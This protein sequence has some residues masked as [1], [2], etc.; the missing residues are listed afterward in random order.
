MLPPITVAFVSHH[1]HLRMG[2]QRSMVLLIEHL[3]RTRV[4]P[5]AICPGP[6]ELTERLRVLD[7]PVTHIPLYRIKPRTLRRVWESS[8]R[9]RALLRQRAVDIVAPDAAR[10]AFTCGLAKLGTPT[11]MVWFVRLTGP[12]NLDFINQHLAD[13][14]IGDSD[15][16]RKRFS[17]S[18]RVSLKYR[19]IVGGVD[20][21]LF[22]PVEDRGP[23]RRQLSLPLDRFILLFVGQIKRAKGV[24]DIVDAMALL[25]RERP[26]DR[27]PLLLLV[28][29][30]DPRE[31]LEEIARRAAAGGV[32]EHVRV[33]PQ[34][35]AI[36]EW[37][38]A[39]DALVSASH[40]DTEGMSRVLYEAMACGAAVIATDISGNREA[41]TP[42]SGI[43]VPEKSPRDLAR[44]VAALANDPARAARYRDHGLRRARE[45]FDIALHARGVEEFYFEVLGRK[46]R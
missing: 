44:A 46:S 6:G 5:L 11:K 34:Q 13:G 12:D 25:G 10:D 14:M 36:Q 21:R 27:L 45:V 2:G 28:G 30:P 22:R 31:I 7:C 3:D 16:T 32:A 26:P 43:L 40:Q 41:L 17:R 23:L 35:P 42:E 38:Q 4:R 39:A 37:M 20:L 18:P 15:D 9:I 1:P 8:R 33:V 29:T 19:T 24:L